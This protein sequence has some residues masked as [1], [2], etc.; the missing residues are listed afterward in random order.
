MTDKILKI[1]K[2]KEYLTELLSKN[3]LEE[4]V[5]FCKSKGVDMSIDDAKQF[6]QIVHSLKVEVEKNNGNLENLSE[7][8]ILDDVVGGYNSSGRGVYD[9][10]DEEIRVKEAQANAQAKAKEAEARA[11]AKA[12]L[13]TYSGILGISALFFGGS[14]FTGAYIYKKVTEGKK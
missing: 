12:I 8:K 6:A 3:S 5:E 7:E 1:V 14:A 13:V 2:N 11:L 10:I 4:I 9:S